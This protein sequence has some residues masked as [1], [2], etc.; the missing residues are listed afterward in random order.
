MDA[1]ESLNSFAADRL[2]SELL[3]CCGSTRWAERMLDQRPF[4]NVSDLLKKADETW[5]SLAPGDWLEAFRSHPKIGEKKAETAQ[6]VVAAAWSKQEQ[7]GAGNATQETTEA[8]A[9][10]NRDYV[11]KYGFIFIVCATGKTANEMLSNLRS[12]LSND[13]DT[14]LRIAAEEQRKITQLRLKKLVA[15]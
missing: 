2:K 10:G 5:W 4:A 11:A 6:S 1:L 13:R 7:S 12:R 14:E 9:S 3:K 8:L 15:L